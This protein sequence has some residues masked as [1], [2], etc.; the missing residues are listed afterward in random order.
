QPSFRA[1]ASQSHPLL[2]SWSLSGVP[3]ARRS[4]LMDRRLCVPP[5]TSVL[6]DYH[7]LPP[8]LLRRPCRGQAG[9]FLGFRRRQSPLRRPWGAG[10]NQELSRTPL[11][12]RFA[13][14]RGAACAHGQPLDQRCP[15]STPCR[16]DVNERTI[17]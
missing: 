16:V 4:T 2:A 8:A 3:V 13:S 15:G 5:S 7:A 10:E 12:L 11:S 9:G 1:A 14:L 6:L 17:S